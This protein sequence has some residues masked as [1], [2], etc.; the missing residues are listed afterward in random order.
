MCEPYIESM[1]G[2][3]V[4]LLEMKSDCEQIVFSLYCKRS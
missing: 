3:E 2:F 4:V 1:R